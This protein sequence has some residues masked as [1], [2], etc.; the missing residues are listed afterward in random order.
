MKTIKHSSWLRLDNAA[1]LYPSVE[2]SR[3]PNLFNISAVL[4]DEVNPEQL[5]QAVNEILPRFPCFSVQL[6]KGIFWYYF[7]QLDTNPAVQ[8]EG[9]FPCPRLDRKTDGKF[10]FRVV[11]SMHRVGV[12]FF[13][14]ITDGYGGLAFLKTL[15]LAYLR[16]C[17]HTIPEGSG[18]FEPSSLPKPEEAEDAY[19]LLYKR[20]KRKPERKKGAFHVSGPL[21]PPGILHLIT[22]KIPLKELKSLS[23]SYNVTITE[24]LTAIYIFALYRIQKMKSIRKQPIRIQVPVNLRGLF[25][26]ET[27]RNFSLFVRPE[28][29][30]ALGEY[31]FEEI[32]KLVHHSIQYELQTK[33]LAAAV[34]ANVA[35]E[36]LFI[37]K[38]LPLWLKKMI[39]SFVFNNFGE[40]LHSGTL[41]NLGL[42][43]LP[44]EMKQQIVDIEI[45]LGH[46]KIN[47]ENCGLVGYGDFLHITFTRTTK[48]T[49]VTREFFSLL[50]QMGLTVTITRSL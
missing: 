11:Y 43:D 26:T 33:Y 1:K 4:K 15:L 39:V 8:K 13:H 27:L 50:A 42:I 20:I 29:N 16:L 40:N 48:D 2:S 30:P 21:E 44:E 10:M 24:Y 46:S 9:D 37:V 47:T 45:V 41:S 22:A 18:I 36:K 7:D 25:H 28:I 17:G 35:L 38:I 6:R 19:G 32:V 14:A 49:A 5:Q 3:Q 23:R 34:N 31:T 12:E